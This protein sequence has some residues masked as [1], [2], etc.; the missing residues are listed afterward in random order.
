MIF[1]MGVLLSAESAECLRVVDKARA[2]KARAGL[3]G[4]DFGAATVTRAGR[5]TR[6]AMR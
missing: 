6:S 5:S 4:Y 2:F 1:A 3:V